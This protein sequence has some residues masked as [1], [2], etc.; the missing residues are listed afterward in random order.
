MKCFLS[1]ASSGQLEYGDIHDIV[2]ALIYTEGRKNPIPGLS[3]DDIAQEIR[4]EC[5]RVLASYDS[6]RIGSSPYKYFQVCIRNRLYNMRR[7][8]YVPN[9]PPCSRCVLWDKEN[10]ECKISEVGCKDIIDYRRN[11]ATKASLRVPGSIEAA[12]EPNAGRGLDID[13]KILD[14]DI[15]V[16]LPIMLIDKYELMLAGC[17]DQVSPRDKRRIREVVKRILQD[18]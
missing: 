11:M 18:A 16:R 15:R 9:N 1:V 8:I 14:H 6:T 2:E 10:K 17:S 12:V 5:L 13:A 4:L 7:G 3:H